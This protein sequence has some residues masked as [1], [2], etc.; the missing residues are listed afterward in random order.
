MAQ[1]EPIKQLTRATPEEKNQRLLDIQQFRDRNA[2]KK[3][4]DDLSRALG[5]ELKTFPIEKPFCSFLDLL[6]PTFNQ[7]HDVTEEN[8]QA[9]IRGL[10]LMALSN[11][12]GYLVLS[13]GNKSELA[14]GYCTLYGDM[15]GGLSVISDVS[16][17]KVY[18]LA[19][20]ING[21]KKVIPESTLT[22]APTAELK[23]NQKDSDTL[24]DYTI[25]DHVLE[26]YVEKRLSL[27]DIAKQYEVSLPFVQGIIHKIHCAE[28]KRRQGAPGLR[29]SPKSFLVGRRY[30]IVQRWI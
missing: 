12:W 27:Q 19:H 13:T 22:K 9:R 20:W 18:E 16:K 24:P 29:V 23:L 5:I 30:P 15:C 7:P 11:K 4:A 14:M 26:A 1:I 21:Q 25:L 8:M 28:Y 6:E 2:S 17:T 3:D 10:I